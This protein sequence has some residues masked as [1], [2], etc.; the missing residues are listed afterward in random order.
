MKNTTKRTSTQV[1]AD[2]LRK[3][4]A[5]NEQNASL[6]LRTA[7]KLEKE[8]RKEQADEMRLQAA[9]MINLA[10][11]MKNTAED[12]APAIEE[13]EKEP[14]AEL[15]KEPEVEPEPE[16]EVEPEKEPE[17][18]PKVEPEKEP[19][20]EPEVEPKPEPEVE[21]EKEP[22]VEPEKE[23]EV[24]PEPEPEVEPEKEPE[25]ELEK[26]PE[27]DQQTSDDKEKKKPGMIGIVCGA[28]VVCLIALSVIAAMIIASR[29][30]SQQSPSDDPNDTTGGIVDTTGP[31]TDDPS[32]LETVFAMS[33]F[34]VAVGNIAKELTDDEDI[35]A[36]VNVLVENIGED[37]LVELIEKYGEL[38]VQKAIAEMAVFVPEI[39]MEQY[40]AIN[41]LSYNPNA[42]A[43]YNDKLIAADETYK[44]ATGKNP[45]GALMSLEGYDTYKSNREAMKKL[46]ADSG[47]LNLLTWYTVK[48]EEY[49]VM[50]KEIKDTETAEDYKE[51]VKLELVNS[52]GTV[53]LLELQLEKVAD[54]TLVVIVDITLEC[55]ESYVQF[56]LANY[57]YVVAKA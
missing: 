4:A 25:V 8:G 11:N 52:K 22:E 20:P 1:T 45:D 10:A 2:E 30:D 38:Q 16:P 28:I 12:L 3:R 54:G 15:E 7:S 47:D 14:E 9:D 24:E 36:N 41:G 29:N 43:D 31:S 5:Q 56:I 26:E 55:T 51:K 37:K 49:D 39:K 53:D 50:R 17:P 46:I 32:V 57:M 23:P 42:E 35:P 34:K 18:E 40:V 6:L 13:P 27:A 48:T 19:E 21:P 33:E 44:K